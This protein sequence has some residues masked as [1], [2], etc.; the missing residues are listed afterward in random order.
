MHGK[1]DRS[2]DDDDEG[3]YL[4]RVYQRGDKDSLVFAAAAETV[5]AKFV[6][7][8]T[9]AHVPRKGEDGVE[10]KPDG[11]RGDDLEDDDLG[12]KRDRH[13]LRNENRQQFVRRGKKHGGERADGY[14]AAGVERCG[15]GGYAALRDRASESAGKRAYGLRPLKAALKRT[16]GVGLHRLKH[17]VGDEEER[18]KQQGLFCEFEHFA[19]YM[20][21]PGKI[22]QSY[23]NCTVAVQSRSAT[24]RTQ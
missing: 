22:P 21:K 20:Y 17:K 16:S 11:D 1:F 2:R 15:R 19:D 24:A 3:E 14:D 23:L 7:V 4:S 8:D 12:H 10:R 6:D 13:L 18:Q 9:A 5:L